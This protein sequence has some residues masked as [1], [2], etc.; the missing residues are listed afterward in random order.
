MR[1]CRYLQSFNNLRDQRLHSSASARKLSIAAESAPS[2]PTASSARL[3]DRVSK[4]WTISSSWHGKNKGAVLLRFHLSLCRCAR[5][6]HCLL[7]AGASKSAVMVKYRP[8]EKEVSYLACVLWVASM[9]PIKN[10]C[11]SP[12]LKFR[13]QRWLSE[14]LYGSLSKSIF[15]SHS[16]FYRYI[17]HK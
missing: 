10:R 11:A 16:F 17:Q 5:P 8:W 12:K 3:M 4:D 6:G 2:K 13:S 9:Y 14:T 15:M 7:A 1:R